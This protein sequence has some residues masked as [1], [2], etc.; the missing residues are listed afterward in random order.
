MSITAKIIADSLT[1][2]GARLTTMQLHYPKFIH[3]EF[4]THRVFSRNAS[5][6]RAIPT[7]RLLE[8]LVSDPV[9]PIG[10]GQ[11]RAGMQAGG[12][13]T[14]GVREN[15]EF[16]WNEAR[17]YAA[18]IARVLDAVGV[19]KQHVNRLI[20]PF[21]HID[22]VV[23]ATEWDNF[24]ELRCHPDAQPEMNVLANEMRGVMNRSRP[25]ELH[26]GEWH[27]PYITDTETIDWGHWDH[28]HYHV[29]CSVARCARVSYLNH[30]GSKPNTRGDLELY[31]RLVTA[32]PMHASPLEHQARPVLSSSGFVY[33]I[34]LL[35][36]A[37]PKD[38]ELGGNLVGWVQYRKLVEEGMV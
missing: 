26:H 23:T 25:R 33:D 24:F 21:S 13:F 6:S 2:A 1:P 7:A 14:D 30:D 15:I 31:E 28:V 32:E 12:E 29:K 8:L 10:L 4:M 16:L 9:I 22:V 35:T 27:L 5:S 36:A 19:H 20:E 17:D 3:G 11:N 37:R 34:N 38:E 18:N